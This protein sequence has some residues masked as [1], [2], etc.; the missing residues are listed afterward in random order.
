M[1]FQEL[2]KLELLS[3]SQIQAKFNYTPKELILAISK[4]KKERVHRKENI[5]EFS[6]DETFGS[7]LSHKEIKKLSVY[8]KAFIKG[9]VKKINRTGE[10]VWILDS[11]KKQRYKFTLSNYFFNGKR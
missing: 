7:F 5:V 2:H 6:P 11:L 1:K 3:L 9:K 10:T 8:F 4:Y